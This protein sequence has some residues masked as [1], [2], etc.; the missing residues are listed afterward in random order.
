MS[1]LPSTFSRLRT[2]ADR[3]VARTDQ[4]TIAASV[5]LV[6]LRIVL[7]VTFAAHGHQVLFGGVAAGMTEGFSAL[8]IPVPAFAVHAT[9]ILQ[10]A[11]G[12][13][14]VLGLL[15]RVLGALL[16]VNMTVALALVHLPAGFFVDDG[17]IELVLLLAG[18]G[19]ALA[20]TG[21]G[22]FSLDA[23]GRRALQRRGT[24]TP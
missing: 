21:A 14:L 12:V 15:T 11:G 10:L 24:P 1:A 3:G 9:A 8:G 22:R 20:L 6:V 23:V 2:L 4:P 17:G 13:A 7:G 5:G 16:A 18:G 19:Y